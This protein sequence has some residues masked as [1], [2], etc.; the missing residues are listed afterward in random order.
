MKFAGKSEQE[1][2]L[3]RTVLGL[4]VTSL[5]AD[6]SHEMATA[7]L[8]GFLATLGA[9]AAALGLIEAVADGLMSLTKFWAGWLSD[10]INRRKP[11]VV[12]G[13]FLTGGA[14]GLLALAT[15]WPFV[16][17]ARA[18]AWFG[19]GARGPVRNSILASSIPAA[20]LGKAFGLER[21]GDSTGAILGPLVGVALLARL[22]HLP[23]LNP[24]FP[25][26]MVFV[27][28]LIPG[29]GA[30][31]SFATLVRETPRQASSLPFRT[32][33]GNLPGPF[34]RALWGIG[35]FGM[36]DFA[37][38]LMILA[39]AQRLSASYGTAH[40][41]QL[42][43]LLYVAHNV[44]YAGF[45]YPAGAL[46]DRFGRTSML[47]AGYLL[48]AMAAAGL[49]LAFAWRISSIPAFLVIF[50]LA[51]V[52]AATGEAVEGAL[53]ADFVTAEARGTAYGAL[54]A[55][56]GVGDFFASLVVGILW[57]IASP[58]VAFVYAATA[59]MAGAILTLRLKRR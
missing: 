21:A 51:G 52:A 17:L 18:A 8:P 44:V 4:G 32:A 9:G 33:V 46:S 25:F 3:N 55:V 31:I 10:R 27:A 54:G 37:R 53:T 34:R 24:A 23:S 41:A 59:M 11:F 14:T 7:V 47:A 30:G 2:W 43:A 12:G 50:A 42:A 6:F 56:N 19:R 38:T 40:A 57:S 48:A 20:S 28:A 1:T 26:R 16:L 5:L 35:V 29:L 45:A 58:V 15:G 22:H 13:Y 39:A 49:A 36:G